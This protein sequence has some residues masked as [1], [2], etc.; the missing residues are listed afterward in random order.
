MLLMK[1][2]TQQT[3]IRTGTQRRREARGILGYE[4]EG[5]QEV[6]YDDV[7]LFVESSISSVVHD[8]APYHH[9]Y[10]SAMKKIHVL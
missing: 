9:S 1:A 5:R 6:Y 3:H 10:I 8:R 2:L 4:G 7:L